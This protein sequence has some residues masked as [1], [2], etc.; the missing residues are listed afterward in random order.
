MKLLNLGFVVATSLTLVAGM[1][2]KSQPAR[3]V[4]EPKVLPE[5]TRA[6]APSSVNIPVQLIENT[7]EENKKVDEALNTTEPVLESKPAVTNASKKA[8]TP[9]AKKKKTAPA[10]K[11]KVKTSKK[12]TKKKN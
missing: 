10:E 8:K 2:S 6:S 7:A 11:S 3:V 4:E 5:S 12:T 1:G 9:A